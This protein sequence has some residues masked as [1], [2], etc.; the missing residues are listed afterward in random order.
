MIDAMTVQRTL[1]KL[2]YWSGKCDGNLADPTFRDALKRFQQDVGLTAD[3]WYGAKSDAVVGA[4]VG[5][6]DQAPAALKQCRRWRLTVYYL[7]EEALYPGAKDTPIPDVNGNALAKVSAGA[8]AAAALEGTIKMNDGRLLNVA[9]RVVPVSG[10]KAA[11]Y[12]GVFAI[13]KKNGW[14]PDK[15][16]YTGLRLD[17]AGAV[18]AVCAFA[19]VP[20]GKIGLGYGTGRGGVPYTPFRTVAADVGAYGPRTKLPSEPRFYGK[21]G[22]SPPGTRAFIADWVGVRLPDGT[23]HD[24]FFTVNDTGGAI[25][26]AHFDVFGGTKSLYEKELKNLRR[27]PSRGHVWFEGI[28]E[29]LPVTYSYGI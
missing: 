14:V 9:G 18:A 25:F 4:Y 24:G 12:D 21:G 11:A 22:V 26:G 8:Y 19:E 20:A 23:T 29:K 28:E 27:W 15:V 2:S 6:L 17:A 7:A 3:G 10:A 1:C 16:G 5:Q 13:A